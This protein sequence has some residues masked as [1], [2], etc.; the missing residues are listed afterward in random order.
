MKKANCCW[1]SI[2]PYKDVECGSGN[3]PSGNIKA[4]IPITEQEHDDL[5]KGTQSADQVARKAVQRM[6][7]LSLSATIKLTASGIVFQMQTQGY[8]CFQK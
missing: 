4:V 5:V 3:D 8:K 6:R 2:E 7:M 1:P